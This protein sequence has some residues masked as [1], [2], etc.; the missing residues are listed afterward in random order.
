MSK[1][2]QFTSA[3]FFDLKSNSYGNLNNMKLD[4]NYSLNVSLG[5]NLASANDQDLKFKNQSNYRFLLR[6][7]LYNS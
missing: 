5:P 7:L 2:V 1:F 6:V 3:D 4:I